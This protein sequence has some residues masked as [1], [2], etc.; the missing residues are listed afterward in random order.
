[1]KIPIDKI[2]IS[3]DNPRQ[4]FDDEGLRRLGE[5]IRTH[6]QL[7]AIIVR[8]CGSNYELVV[9]ERR[10]RACALVG[11]TEIEAELKNI[12]DSTVMELRLIENTQREDLTDAEKGDAVLSLWANYGKYDTLKAVAEAI[13]IPYDTIRKGWIPKATKLSSKVRCLVGTTSFSEEH[14]R[15]VMMYPHSV[16]EKLAETSIK[17]KLTKRQLLELTKL[18]DASPSTDLDELANKVL[19]VVMVE[20]PKSMISPVL[21]AQMDEKRQLDKVHRVRSKRS[22]TITKEDVQKQQ[23]KTDFKFVKATVSHGKAGLLPPLKMEVKPTII[24]NPNTPDYT[25][26]KCALCPLFATHC[27]GRCWT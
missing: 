27:K 8:Q 14:A 19:G 1:M 11:L 20:V 25:L 3:K 10:L 21:Q 4:N 23:K 22:K 9:G 16:Q 2:I 17:H 13:K 7:Q 12:D 24:P 15:Y 18:H 6:G 5:S 26:C